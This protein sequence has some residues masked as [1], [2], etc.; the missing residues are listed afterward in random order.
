MHVPASPRGRRAA[1]SR[2][3]VF[4]HG[5]FW[6]RCPEHFHAPQANA[7]CGQAGFDSVFARD[8]DTE[9]QSSAAGWLVVVVLQAEDLAQ[10][11]QRLAE[12]YATRSRRR[13]P[14]A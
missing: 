1:L 9:R 8:V 6:H 5:C 2:I 11:A 13:G 12:L 3:A 7:A 10:A 4:V 14:S